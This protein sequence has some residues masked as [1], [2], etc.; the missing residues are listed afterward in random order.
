MLRPP[1]TPCSDLPSGD[2]S[3][4]RRR[5]FRASTH[6]RCKAR[7]RLPLQRESA[8]LHPS[9]DRASGD[10]S[11]AHPEGTRL[12][13][14]ILRSLAL[15]WLFSTS[16]IVS[17][18][19]PPRGPSAPNDGGSGHSA[20][21]LKAEIAAQTRRDNRTR[22]LSLLLDRDAS[23]AGAIAMN[24]TILV[25][26]MLP[27][28]ETYLTDPVS[29]ERVEVHGPDGET[30]PLLAT[31]YHATNGDFTLSIRA[32]MKRDGGPKSPLVSRGIPY[33]G[34]GRL[35]LCFII[36][37]AR[38]RETATINLGR[39]LTAFC[40][41]VDITPSG[42][43]KGRARYVVDQLQRLA[44]CVVDF[45][46]DTLGKGRKSTRGEQI[47]IVDSYHFW[48]Q[49]ASLH[50]E[51]A[52]GGTITLSGR[53][54]DDVVSSCFPLDFRKAQ[55]FR[56]YPTAYD[57]Y[58]WL[59]YKLGQMERQGKKVVGVNYDDLHA[60]LG[61]H[62]QTDDDGVLTRGGKDEFGRNVRKALKA[63]KATWPG[64]DVETP[65]EPR[66]APHRQR[67]RRRAPGTRQAELKPAEAGERNAVARRWPPP[68]TGRQRAARRAEPR[69]SRRASRREGRPRSTVSPAGYP[70]IR[71]PATPEYGPQ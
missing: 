33:G 26:A 8:P 66:R 61:S 71:T 22:Q 9:H 60:Q 29:G 46:W 62:Y 58:L 14:P 10:E 7:G 57:L 65:R 70:R 20:R 16:L 32:G 24:P 48:H 64:L 4:G 56:G 11:A 52:S 54:W 35:L 27:H 39:T 63:I 31:H 15:G 23:S 25:Q 6:P 55:Y 68:L 38:K 3:L 50:S 40:E 18:T 30:Q 49:E 17:L 28:K 1:P 47:L 44:T 51:A 36:T 42:G 13:T 69:P 19:L 53:F 34:L 12:R 59:T 2:P 21:P 67:P 43:E 41:H 5:A 37:E 45:H